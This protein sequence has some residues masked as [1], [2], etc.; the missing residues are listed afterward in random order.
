MEPGA[1]RD[2]Q[3]V[4][5]FRDQEDVRGIDL[6]PGGDLLDDDPQCE[7]KILTHADRQRDGPDDRDAFGVVQQGC[8][9]ARVL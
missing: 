4:A 1:G 7:G 2:E 6:E 9:K 8:L 5:L 3:L